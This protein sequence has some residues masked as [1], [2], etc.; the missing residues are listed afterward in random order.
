MDYLP[1]AFPD[2]ELLAC[3]YLRARHAG[4]K[5]DRKQPATVPAIVVRDDSGPD[6]GPLADRR[7]GFR[8]CGAEGTHAATRATAEAVAASL[9]VWP[10]N[11][12]EV[13]AVDRVRGPWATS[14][15][16][17]PPEF[18]LTAEV[19]LLGATS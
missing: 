17:A 8:V 12:P 11:T 16:D 6:R 18:Y 9:R 10:L 14:E 7:M 1:L 13:V 4:V 5:V 3:T 15:V 2:A 19:T